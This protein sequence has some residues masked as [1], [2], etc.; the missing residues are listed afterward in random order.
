MAIETTLRWVVRGGVFALPFVAFIVANTLFFPFITGKN[1]AFRVI[2]EVMAGAYLALALLNKEYRPRR[3]WILGAFALLVLIM[4]AADAF[5][6]NPTRSFW[7]NFERM[8]G[9]VTLAH[10]FVYLVVVASV[11]RTEKSWR[12]VWYAWL[13]SAFLMSIYGLSQL[14]GKLA[15][16]SQSGVRLDT[17]FG[18][19]TYLAIYMLFVVF[20]AAYMLADAW[21]D[22]RRGERIGGA[23]VY[24]TLILI[25]TVVLFF[26]ATR[27]AILGLA[28][29]ALVAFVISVWGHLHTRYARWGIGVVAIAIALCAGVYAARDTAAVQSVEPLRRLTSITLT[30]TT[31][32]A[33]FMNWNMAWQGVKERPLLGWGQENYGIV[34][35]KYYDPNMYAQEQWFDRVHNIIFDWL[36]AGGVLGFAAYAFLYACAIAGLWARG[37]FTQMERGI[38]TG[39]LVGYLFHNL[40]VFDNLISYI[41]F[42]T[43]L[44][45]IATRVAHARGA[46]LVVHAPEVPRALAPIVAVLVVLG[47]WGVAYAVNATPLAQNK[48]LLQ[49][50][51]PHTEGPTKNLE[52]YRKAITYGGVGVQEARE[53]LMQS[54]SQA[55]A[56]QSASAELKGQF[57]QLAVEEMAAQAKAVPL[58]ARFPLFLGALLDGAGRYAEAEQTLL[59]ARALSP[60]KQS[61]IFALG[62]NAL[63]RGD[64][65]KAVAYFNEAY[66]LAPDYDDA[67][68]LYV[69][70][71]VAV[72]RMSEAD[73]LI[74]PVLGTER[75]IHSRIGTAYVRVNRY[76]KAAWVWGAYAKAHPQDQT[77]RLT[78]AAAYYTGGD[79]TRAIEVLRQAA[80]DIPAMA[81][82]AQTLISQ[83]QSGRVAQ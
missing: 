32:I 73:A 15:I 68:A 82:Q 54:A 12:A 80:N 76:D 44:G 38:L 59:Q 39:L 78:L 77:A 20:I 43:V 56:S 33:R 4:A 51:A 23:V 48:A 81:V 64:N 36:I 13:G 55:L 3:S 9:W 75:S 71:L 65:A 24:G 2:V 19:A 50:L 16:S 70:S 60:H 34:F 17:T 5:G 18:N 7:S 57:I 30:D 45:Y 10:L 83:I 66:E 27:G 29:G 35:S 1:F 25:G 47:V 11:F 52:Y 31:V 67:F 79:H 14:F 69:A 74:T 37:A 40:F 41:L 22:G 62:A 58:E 53:Q 21:R 26:T 42:A 49:A 72:G 46:Q 61:I 63:A 8:D 6:V 28:L